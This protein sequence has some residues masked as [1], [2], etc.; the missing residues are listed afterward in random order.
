MIKTIR[1]EYNYA[2]NEGY[3]VV[4]LDSDPRYDV[5]APD[6][7]FI[8]DPDY[9]ELIRYCESIRARDRDYFI[10]N[11]IIFILIPKDSVN[12][13]HLA[14]R[15]A[16][17]LHSAARE[18]LNTYLGTEIDIFVHEHTI[19]GGVPNCFWRQFVDI[20]QDP[21]RRTFNYNLHIVQSD[22]IFLNDCIDI[23]HCKKYYKAPKRF[24]PDEKFFAVMPKEY[25]L[26]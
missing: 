16:A 9:L 13:W 3:R 4:L 11:G 7:R 14:D 8:Q 18:I 24:H 2:T 17:R 5:R 22:T 12:N 15:V 23:T 26:K 1:R 25:P 19:C 21:S 6:N 20:I 10:Y